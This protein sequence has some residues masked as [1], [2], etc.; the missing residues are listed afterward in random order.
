[1][2]IGL[3]WELCEGNWT[4]LQIGINYNLAAVRFEVLNTY[5]YVFPGATSAFVAGARGAE[6]FTRSEGV[7]AAAPGWDRD[8]GVT[9]PGLGLPVL[10]Q[11]T[12]TRQQHLPRERRLQSLC[13]P[14]SLLAAAVF[15]IT[16]AMPDELPAACPA[17]SADAACAGQTRPR[18][19]TRSHTPI[20][21]KRCWNA[22]GHRYSP[23]GPRG[24]RCPRSS[25]GGNGAVSPCP[26]PWLL[27]GK[28]REKRS[29][30]WPAPGVSPSPFPGA[31][32]PTGWSHSST[33]AATRSPPAQESASAWA[34][35]GCRDQP[36]TPYGLAPVH[37]DVQ[38]FA[39]SHRRL[40]K[41]PFC[42]VYAIFFPSHLGLFDALGILQT[43]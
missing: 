35:P 14:C 26:G 25:E 16:M 30:P 24:C 9:G 28:H 18:W 38:V 6:G 29:L 15:S 5:F 22:Q 23:E 31:G 34:A 17:W 42:F 32:G 2:A 10:L 8:I 13:P 21:P 1:M 7:L 36:Q 4:E 3:N 39:S 11:C 40:T 20:A 19:Q 43:F 27:L 33:T 41:P 12:R 37:T